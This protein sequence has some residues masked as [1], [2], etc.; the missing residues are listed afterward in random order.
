MDELRLLA[1][2]LPD[3][4]PPSAEVVKQAHARLSAAQQ[5]PVRPGRAHRRGL[6][7]GWTLGAAAAT[8]A[9]VMA[10]VTL[11]SNVIAAP[12]PMLVPASGND[13][14]LRLADL[15]AKQPD[16][17]G[18][19]WRRPLLNNGLTRV[20]AGGETF[21]VLISSR[22]DLWQ[23]RDPHDP[24]Q[25][26]QRQQ[27]VRPAT[28]ADERAWRTAGSP[29]TVQRVCTPG[30]S[31]GDCR[32]IRLRSKPSQCVYTRAAKPSG[33]LGDSRLDEL[34]LADL[35]ALPS[36]PGQLR[37][38]LRTFWEARK[39]S[40]SKTSFEAFLATSSVLLELPV[41]PAV[42]AAALRLLAGL[43]TTKVHGSIVDP[44]GRP[45]IEVTFI[46]SEGFAGEFG[47]DDEVAQRF[48]TV[49][50]PRT[51]TVL[52]ANVAIAAESAEGLAKGTFMDYQ[53]WAAEAGWTSDRP[54]R[55]SGC[56]LSNRQLS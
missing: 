40:R 10:V 23:P 33:V 44:L 26:E 1:R 46:K 47:T 2:S 5:E 3:A 8:V 53:A 21:N 14:L 4:P 15:V 56:R 29:V 20:R 48:A 25:A 41:R 16:E 35:A 49:L 54:E 6:V 38:K 11:V 37:E 32:K 18:A 36:D 50:D 17:G 22:I 39:D 30:T 24:V 27:F 52:A 12:T 51:G 45:G 31:A 42:R 19:Y 7:W 9:I 28:K 55:P 34:T 13:V 43:P